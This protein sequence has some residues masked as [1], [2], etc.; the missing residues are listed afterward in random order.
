MWIPF[1]VDLWVCSHLACDQ[2][3]VVTLQL[4][5][6]TAASRCTAYRVIISIFFLSL[7]PSP[8]FPSPQYWIVHIP[9]H[10][11]KMEDSCLLGSMDRGLIWGGGVESRGYEI[12]FSAL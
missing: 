10:S 11:I 12:E 9:I 8:H 7:L 2:A 4:K 3:T 1:R 5:K 6:S